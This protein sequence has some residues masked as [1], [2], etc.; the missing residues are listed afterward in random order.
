MTKEAVPR[1]L[2]L[3]YFVSVLGHLFINDQGSCSLVTRFSIYLSISITRNEKLFYGFG[4]KQG[5]M[6]L[7]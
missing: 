7:P 5:D 2:V 1:S 3:V 6:G 4:F